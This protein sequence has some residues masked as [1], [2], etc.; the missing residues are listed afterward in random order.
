[1]HK[2]YICKYYLNATHSM[3]SNK[4]HAHTFTVSFWIEKPQKDMIL[5]FSEIDKMIGAY[6]QRFKG[7]YLNEEPEFMSVSTTLENIG[8]IFFEEIEKCLEAEDVTLV[9]VEICENPLR[10]Y[11]I[12]N[13]IVLASAYTDNLD[14]IL[15]QTRKSRLDCI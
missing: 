1:M 2:Y 6:I 8:E 15:E 13:R 11:S 4:E 5:S 7:K 10:V 12:S 14:S 9:Q 3:N